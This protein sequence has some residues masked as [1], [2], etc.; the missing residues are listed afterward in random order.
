MHCPTPRSIRV[1]DANQD[2]SS[3]EVQMITL[4]SP[5]QCKMKSWETERVFPALGET[6]SIQEEEESEDPLLPSRNCRAQE[7]QAPIHRVVT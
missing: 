3:G 7:R 2:L 4:A 5:P 6:L 1:G